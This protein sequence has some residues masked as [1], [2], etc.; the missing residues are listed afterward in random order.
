MQV[1]MGAAYPD[2]VGDVPK[3]VEL[4]LGGRL[5][6]SSSLCALFCEVELLVPSDPVPSGNPLFV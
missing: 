5:S 4:S 1:C 6:E 3:A 2:E